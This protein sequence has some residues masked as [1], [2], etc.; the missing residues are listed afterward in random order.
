[1][2]T[3]LRIG[4]CTAALLI[5]SVARAQDPA[6]NQEASRLWLTVGVVA[7]TVHGDCQECTVEFPYHHNGGMVF[8]AGYR[9]SRRMDVGGDVFWMPFETI[10]GHINGFH[11]DAVAQFRPWQS[12]G[13]FVKGGAGMAYVKNWAET[14]SLEPINSKALSVVIGGGWAFNPEA[15]VGLQLF[16]EQRVAAL[17][18]LQL[19]PNSISDVAGNS[20]AVGA[21][22]VIR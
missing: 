3:W 16:A 14:T 22:I 5:P 11:F 1:M 10:T 21:A 8:N 2:R 7:G 4:I 13:F 12:R 6:G 20:W 17:G 18:D 15:R 9:V 19:G